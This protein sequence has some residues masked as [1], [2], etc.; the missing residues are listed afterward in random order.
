[1]AW[2]AHAEG[3]P[4]DDNTVTL[5]PEVKDARGLPVARLTYEWTANDRSLSAAAR[6]TAAAM[7]H[8]SGA[9]QVRVGLH[10]GAHAM[11]TCRMGDDPRTSVANPP[12]QA[13]DI[14]NLFV[15]DTSVFV[16]STG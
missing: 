4:S 2:W 16:T 3:L 11:R 10:Y 6:D 14:R 1:A 12:G 8:A 5:D 15:C 9:R 13:H 7:M